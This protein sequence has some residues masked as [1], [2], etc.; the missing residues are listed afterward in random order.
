MTAVLSQPLNESPINPRAGPTWPKVL[1]P[2][3]MMSDLTSLDLKKVARPPHINVK[4]HIR[5]YGN[6]DN[7]PLW[8]KRE[9][10][11]EIR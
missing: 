9:N 7:S 6:A 10:N 2:F 5:K 3:L 4:T 11:Y 8:K 1:K